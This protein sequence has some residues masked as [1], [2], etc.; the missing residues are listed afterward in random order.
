MLL[1]ATCTAEVKREILAAMYLSESEMVTVA[2]V[3]DR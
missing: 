2:A 3:P 1:T